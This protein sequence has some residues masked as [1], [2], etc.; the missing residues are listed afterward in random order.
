MWAWQK[1]Y[2]DRR[3]TIPAAS[4]GFGV[5]R[6]VKAPAFEDDGRSLENAVGRTLANRT[7][8]FHICL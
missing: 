4:G 7:D 1:S 5:I 8:L 3:S 6:H 2:I